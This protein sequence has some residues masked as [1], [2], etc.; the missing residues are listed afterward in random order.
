MTHFSHKKTAPNN[1]YYYLLFMALFFALPL[2]ATEASADSNVRYRKPVEVR[3]VW[4]DRRSI[5][6]SEQEI[7]LLVRKYADAG[8]NLIFP[9]VIYN[10]FTAY[11][12]KVLP[13]QNLWNGLD[14]LKIIVEEG[15][16]N[17][18]EVHPWVWVFRAG[19][20]ADKGGI[21]AT[22]PD[23]AAVGK[24]GSIT[25]YNGSYWLC[26]SIPE[27][28]ELLM[29]AYKELIT[30]YKVD[31]IHLDYI[32][33][34]DQSAVST[35]YNT[36]CRE[37]FAK[38][39][40]VD[41]CL[42]EPFTKSVI[43]W[44]LWR[45]EQVNSFICRISDELRKIRLNLKISAAVGDPYD[46]AR[47]NLLQNWMN[48]VDNRW[49]DFLVPMDYT[50][51][52]GSFG[53]RV[54]L[55][56]VSAGNR[57]LIIP[58]IGVH[59]L[60]DDDQA[61]GQIGISRYLTA[62]GNALFASSYIKDSL[63]DNLKHDAFLKP[64][65]IP[66]RDPIKKADRMLTSAIARIKPSMKA[67][68]VV[69][70][71]FDMMSANTLTQYNGWM[72][73]KLGY[74]PPVQPKIFIPD[75]VQPIPETVAVKIEQPITIDGQLEDLWQRVVPAM[76]STTNM[77]D[78]VSKPTQIRIAYDASNLY[79]CLAVARP[80]SEVR[81]P[82]AIYHDAPVFQDDSFEVFIDPA[83]TGNSYFHFA[84]NM[85]GVKFEQ[86][87]FD[88]KWDGDWN[89]A[90]TRNDDIWC[91]EF[92]IPYSSLGVTPPSIGDV[93]CVNFCRNMYSNTAGENSCWSATYGGYHTPS[94]FGRLRFQ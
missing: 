29:S 39:Y 9:E 79:V 85:I 67:D 84:V 86:K 10:G 8:F 36:S 2:L 94:R 6:K 71:L 78:H 16:R 14:V 65:L 73:S 50:A 49:V 26:P 75:V 44:H 3:A 93:W 82:T 31:G 80:L 77:G 92:A 35:C 7:R 88:T 22:H 18:I 43:D 87:V 20:P 47:L 23:W 66:Y 32:R 46:A 74:I 58:G 25:G 24:D 91:A 5:P 89:C 55:D 28:R 11:P 27:V 12:G 54:Q 38:E 1:Q 17:R 33:F 13:M 70:A 37:Q 41:P 48:W 69:Y 81:K 42:I 59:L 21:I 40:G 57:T 15:H 19:Y 63:L 60:R 90:V 4:M 64:A 45:E 76:I 34:D 51:N 30:T 53:R 72:K 52:D 61:V 68:D 56:M 62:S 83:G